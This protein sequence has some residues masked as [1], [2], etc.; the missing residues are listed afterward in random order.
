VS[1]LDP[2][3]LG[4]DSKLTLINYNGVWNGNTFAGF[5][6]NSTF[7]LG[8][9]TWQIRYD[10]IDGGD[11]FLGDN[12]LGDNFLGEQNFSNYL[13]I[14]TIAAIPEPS[15]ALLGGLGVFALLRRRRS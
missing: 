2:V 4:L 13:T 12:F 3:L 15:A 7:L 14:T 10:D 11:N 1:N 9:N 6:N 5:A 8:S